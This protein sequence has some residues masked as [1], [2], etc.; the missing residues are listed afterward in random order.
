VRIAV[1]DVGS[2][3][4]HL[5][6]A[7]V[8]GELPLPVQAHKVKLRLA[9]R[10]D[11]AGV[12]DAGAI[13]L[14][15][16]G[17]AAGVEK[18]A[19]CGVQ[20]LFGYATAV[21]RDAPNRDEVV[22]AVRERAGISLGVLPGA[23]EAQ[24]TFLA[25]RRWMGWRAGPMLVLDIGGGSFEVAFGQ[26]VNAEFAVSL[27][28]G[29]GRLTRRWLSGD[30]PGKVPVKRLRRHVR[31]QLEELAVRLRWSGRGTAVATSR[32]FHQLAR[33]CGAAKP[34]EGPFV[35]RVLRR[36]DLAAQ[37][38]RLAGMSSAER[39]RLPGISRARARQSLAGAVVAHA[40]MSRFGLD[41]VTLCPWALREG[42]LLRRVENAAAWTDRALTLGVRPP[43]PAV[44][45]GGYA[46][47]VDLDRARAHH[48][49]P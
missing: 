34:R 21:V 30:P 2:N 49:G 27:P 36:E 3:T 14:L 44:P 26:D 28:L 12:L 10:V 23:E 43:R 38:R 25:A 33:L 5:L 16:A 31:E 29:A 18:A 41:E 35:P 15:A 6:I 11:R 46:A 42:L 20:E 8:R 32:T 19:G 4:S 13:S 48:G 1:L 47:V 45:P 22:A 37:V 24:L 9:E 17:V 40:A 7:D 39:A